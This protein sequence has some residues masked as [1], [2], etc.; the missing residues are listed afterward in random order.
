[1]RDLKPFDASSYLT[2]DEIIDEFLSICREDPDPK[3]YLGALKEVEKALAARSLSDPACC[4]QH[5]LSI[6]HPIDTL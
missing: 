3:V 2:S 5:A 4:T 1:M 6:D